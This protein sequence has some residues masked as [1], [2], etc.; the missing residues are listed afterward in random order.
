MSKGEPDGERNIEE[1]YVRRPG[2]EKKSMKI[3]NLHKSS[4]L[5]EERVA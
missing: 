3:L 4:I 2:G 1:P 5:S